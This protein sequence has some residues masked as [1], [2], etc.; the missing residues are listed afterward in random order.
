MPRP[1]VSVYLVTAA[2]AFAGAVAGRLPKLDDEMLRPLEWF[3][4]WRCLDLLRHAG[5]REHQSGDEDDEHR[6]ERDA[7]VP[8]VRGASS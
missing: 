5:R 1:L 4:P 6:A 3:G 8:R 2:P 7:Q